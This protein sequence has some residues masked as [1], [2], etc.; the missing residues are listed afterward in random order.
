MSSR[1]TILNILKYLLLFAAAVLLVYL[2]FRKVDWKVFLEGLRQTRWF[3]VAM[4][5]VLSV[6]ALLGRALR[7]KELLLPFDE[8]INFLKVW[9]ADNV[10]NLASAA[11]PGTG[12]LLRCGYISSK[13]VEFD[14]TFGTMLCERVWDFIAIVVLLGTALALQWSKFGGYFKENIIAP[15]TSAGVWWILLAVVAAAA[16]FIVIMFRFRDR[17]NFCC[18]VAESI[19]R[20]GSGIMA[21]HKSKNKLLIAITTFFIWF[22]YVLMC[23]S[24]IKAMPALDGMTLAD[25]AFLSMVGNIAS[26]IPVPGGVG[27][28]HYLV[29]AAI[30]LYGQS[31]DTGL[32]FATLNHETHA[33]LV[34]AL[35][36]ISYVSLV[37]RTGSGKAAVNSQD[38]IIHKNEE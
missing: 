11:L 37:R 4:F 21:F 8:K 16:L 9:D 26:I 36:I 23:W 7:W 19:S 17:N 32:L 30:G 3:W 31:W 18:K 27:A 33:L 12:E 6:L 25:A 2:A 5:C 35:G 29:A 14:K 28:Y 34:I 1:K 22:V 24:I 38:P 20:L 15:M 10:G 13:K